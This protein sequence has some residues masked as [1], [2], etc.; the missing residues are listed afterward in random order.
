MELTWNKSDCRSDAH[1]LRYTSTLPLHS[2]PMRGTQKHTRKDP[3]PDKLCTV[4]ALPSFRA[5]LLAPNA[6]FALSLQ[7]SGFPAM[8]RYSCRQ[9]GQPLHCYEY[10]KRHFVVTNLSCNVACTHAIPHTLFALGSLT[11]F[12]SAFLTDGSTSGFPSC[13]TGTS[14]KDR[15]LFWCR[16]NLKGCTPLFYTL[17]HPDSVSWSRCP[18]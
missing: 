6:N 5:R 10:T 18:P 3:V 8:P 13:G 9:P 12:C 7:K 11:T 17:Q 15:V 4:A 1:R 2:V 16:R 14:S